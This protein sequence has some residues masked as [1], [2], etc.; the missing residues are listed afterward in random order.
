MG[1][2]YVVD[3]DG[4]SL[5]Q[6]APPIKPSNSVLQGAPQSRNDSQLIRYDLRP[7]SSATLPIF[8]Q[9]NIH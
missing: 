9:H 5:V 3:H 1:G 8:L 7:L 2:R 4:P 6:I